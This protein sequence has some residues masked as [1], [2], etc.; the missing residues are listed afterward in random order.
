MH[1]GPDGP[2]TG[3]DGQA[4]EVTVVHGMTETTYRDRALVRRLH[5]AAGK[6]T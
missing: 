2:G 3:L 6:A 4:G 1:E 5:K